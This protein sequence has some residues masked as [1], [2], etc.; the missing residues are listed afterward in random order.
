MTK[1]YLKYGKDIKDITDK[2]VM[3]MI[4]DCPCGDQFRLRVIIVDDNFENP[5]VQLAEFIKEYEQPWKS[6]WWL[7][8]HTTWNGTFDPD[9]TWEII[10]LDKDKNERYY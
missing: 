6:D 2:N 4:K 5:H 3:K 1:L 9:N 10:D 7:D 8:D